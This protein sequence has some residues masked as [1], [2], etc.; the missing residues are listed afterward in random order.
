[1][2][3]GSSRHFVLNSLISLTSIYCHSGTAT[4]T[5]IQIETEGCYQTRESGGLAQKAQN[6]E[7]ETGWTTPRTKQ[8]RTGVV[9]LFGRWHNQGLSHYELSTRG[10][11]G[12]DEITVMRR[13]PLAHSNVTHVG[14]DQQQGDTS[15]SSSQQ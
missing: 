3:V 10:R 4:E 1:M 12:E 14:V 7:S 13:T 5:E 9:T 2:S 15:D 11:V 6:T 8:R